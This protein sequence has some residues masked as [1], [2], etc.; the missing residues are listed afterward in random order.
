M[1]AIELILGHA[2]Y[3]IKVWDSSIKKLVNLDDEAEAYCYNGP[4]GI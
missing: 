2:N 4:N 3:D 1:P